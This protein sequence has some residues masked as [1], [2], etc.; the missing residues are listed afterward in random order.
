M[1][2]RQLSTYHVRICFHIENKKSEIFQKFAKRKIPGAKP[3]ADQGGKH[4][5][6]IFWTDPCLQPTCIN[7]RNR[8]I[9]PSTIICYFFNKKNTKLKGTDGK[10]WIFDPRLGFCHFGRHTLPPIWRSVT[11]YTHT[12]A[13]MT[14]L[15]MPYPVGLVRWKKKKKMKP[16]ARITFFFRGFWAP[17]PENFDSISETV[18]VSSETNR[19]AQTTYLELTLK[20]KKKKKK[21]HQNWKS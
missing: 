9:S 15:D 21:K 17:N 2:N 20:K 14:A 12:P 3:T 7:P 19:P 18:P 5:K 13:Q 10:K 16:T 4:L 6:S 8:R 11:T 1:R